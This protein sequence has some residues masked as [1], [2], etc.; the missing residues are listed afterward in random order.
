MGVA[1]GPPGALPFIR[2][3]VDAWLVKAVTG[4]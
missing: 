4:T 1:A 2:T 3:V